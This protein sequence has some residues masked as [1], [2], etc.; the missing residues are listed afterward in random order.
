MSVISIG[1]TDLAQLFTPPIT[2]LNW[3]L[4]AVGT[5]CAEV[6]LRSLSTRE[7]KEP[8][9]ILITTQ[10]ILRE[11]CMPPPVAARTAVD[12]TN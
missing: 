1:D 8:E 11:S 9:R 4:A 6:M 3:D 5:A 7:A 2:S 10:M 12:T